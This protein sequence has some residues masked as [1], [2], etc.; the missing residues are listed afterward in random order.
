MTIKERYSTESA[1]IF[2]LH[3]GGADGFTVAARLTSL[4]DTTLSE[5]WNTSPVSNEFAVVALGGY[6]R[7]EIC[8]HSD[9][10]LMILAED[11]ATA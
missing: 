6:G 7:F 11:S 8:P 2:K 10:D 1:S 3:R 4:V 5:L 9:F